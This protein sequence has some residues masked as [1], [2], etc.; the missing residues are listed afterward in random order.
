[1]TRYGTLKRWADNLRLGN[2]VKLLDATLKEE[3]KTDLDLTALADELANPKA[4]KAAE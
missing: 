3:T 1:M 2:A 4:M